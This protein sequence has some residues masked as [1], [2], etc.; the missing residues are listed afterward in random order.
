LKL[1]QARGAEIC[2]IDHDGPAIKAGLRENDVILQM[3]GQRVEG[4]EQFR[5]MLHETPAGRTVTFVLSRNG[6]QQTISVQLADRDEVARRAWD[7]HFAVPEPPPDDAMI[8]D[9]MDEPQPGP[10]PAQQRRGYLGFGFMGPAV[11]SNTY[12]GAM[13]DALGPQLAQFFGAKPG[14]GLLI[15]SIDA[16]SPAARA[17]LQAGDV[18]TRING[19]VVST[20]ADWIHAVQSSHGKAIAV[21]VLRE[22]HEQTLSMSLSG[23][24]KHSELLLMEHPS[25]VLA[26]FHA[27]RPPP[28]ADWI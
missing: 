23:K 17:G 9:P 7:D 27:H 18:V 12:T 11:I 3:N 13:L 22:K 21:T 10:P 5:R 2:L 14:T 28:P 4:E 24:K 8:P 1:K 20:R 26:H 6:R 16:D 15:K 19:N 25:L